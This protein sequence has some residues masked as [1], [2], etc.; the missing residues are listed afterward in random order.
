MRVRVVEL[1]WRRTGEGPLRV[2][3][4]R[5]GCGCAL[6]E[7]PPRLL[8]AGARGALRLKLHPRMRNGPF[9][10]RLR[11]YTTAPPP[12]DRVVVRVRGHVR[13]SFSFHPPALDLGARSPGARL[14]REIEVRWA[15]PEDVL[16]PTLAPDPDSDAEADAAGDGAAEVESPDR[17]PGALRFLRAELIG[18]EGRARVEPPARDGLP[19]CLLRLELRVPEKS[20]P[21]RGRS[22]LMLGRRVLGSVPV[23][24]QVESVEPSPPPR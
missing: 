22:T 6:V 1:P 2:L 17:S 3:G 19:G 10:V 21:F 18:L 12:A 24:G 11:V 13:G 5:T 7:D 8:P 14:Q 15:R 16:D 9:L 4:V 23:R 20:G